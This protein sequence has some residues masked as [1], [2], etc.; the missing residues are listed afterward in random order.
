ML[1]ASSMSPTCLRHLMPA[2]SPISNRFRSLPQQG[3]FSGFLI[4]SRRVDLAIMLEKGGE[5]VQRQAQHPGRMALPAPTI[6]PSAGVASSPQ[7]ASS[8]CNYIDACKPA[9]GAWPSS[10]RNVFSLSLDAGK[11]GN[12]ASAQIMPHRKLPLLATTA[13]ADRHLERRGLHRSDVLA[14]VT[15]DRTY[16]TQ[17]TPQSKRRGP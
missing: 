8:P 14:S 9:C 12:G 16:E 15:E 2:C 5:R 4:A 10:S 1:P 13:L 11:G 17:D 7:P 3:W 6:L